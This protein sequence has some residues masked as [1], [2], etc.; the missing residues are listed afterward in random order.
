MAL[1]LNKKQELVRLQLEKRKVPTDIKLAVKLVLD[2]SGSIQDLFYNGTMQELVDRLIPVAM[3]FDDNQSIE[4]YAFGSNITKV[5]DVKAS[6]F[7]SYVTSKFLG[8]VPERILWSGTKYATALARV[9]S[10][11][12]GKSGVFG[13]L[14]GKKKV[15]QQAYVMFVT[16]GETQG[17]EYE[18]EKLLSEYHAANVYVQ[19]IG[20]GRAT[21]FEFL[22]RMADKFSNVGFVT[23][24][25]LEKTSDEAMYEALLGE[26]LCTWVKAQ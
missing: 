1:D 22:R 13:G 12:K 18:T 23:F 16:D 24:P 26:E 15:A 25:D 11:T 21:R 8:E 6:D 19:L 3:R 9:L 20:V 7:G 14:F 5:S 17:D 10:E 4:A 2:V